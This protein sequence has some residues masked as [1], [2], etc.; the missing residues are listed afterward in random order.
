MSEY[1]FTARGDGA[2]EITGLLTFATVPELLQQSRAWL[3]DDH[4]ELAI[5]LGGVTRADSAGLALMIEWLRLARS[6]NRRLR[7]IHIPEQLQNL[8]RV[9]GLD[10]V[11]DAAPA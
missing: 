7:F 11:F 2:F 9:S 3:A 8:I 1:A 5:D 6:R 4:R 10:G